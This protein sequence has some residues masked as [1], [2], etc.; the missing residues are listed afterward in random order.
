MVAKV[1]FRHS[2]LCAAGH[3]PR[4]TEDQQLCRRRSSC[5][6]GDLRKRR[7]QPISPLAG[8]MSGRTEGGGKE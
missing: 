3:L 5:N 4:R 7:R 1:A 6:V 8:E 2:P